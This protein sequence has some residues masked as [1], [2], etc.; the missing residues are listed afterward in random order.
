M[1]AQIFFELVKQMRAA[2]K[3]YFKERTQSNLIESKKL[4]KQVD[5]VLAAGLD[6]Q[7]EAD[8]AVQLSLTE[9]GGG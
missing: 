7:A 4:E 6:N 5:Q 8:V 1:N 3:K 9:N 2:Q